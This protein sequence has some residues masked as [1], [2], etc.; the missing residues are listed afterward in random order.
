MS[1]ILL[2][3][4]DRDG[5]SGIVMQTEPDFRVLLFKLRFLLMILRWAHRIG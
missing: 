5:A 2:E 4:T 3:R 1:L